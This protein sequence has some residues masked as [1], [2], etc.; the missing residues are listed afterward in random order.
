MTKNTSVSFCSTNYYTI[1][2]KASAITSQEQCLQNYANNKNLTILKTFT[3]TIGN[4]KREKLYEMLY[5]VTSN[6]IDNIL[7]YKIENLTRNLRDFSL[8]D[9]WLEK[10]E[11]HK[12]HLVNQGTIIHK[13]S[14]STEKF[15]LSMQISLSDMY[16]KKCTCR[17]IIALHE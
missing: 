6:N 17:S 11:N 4:K 1:D 2:S 13:N 5:F 8:L 16:R 7:V 14:T 9:D 15:S 3:S 12:L 10:D